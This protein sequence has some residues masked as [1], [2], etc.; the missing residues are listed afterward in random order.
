MPTA[1]QHFVTLSTANEDALRILKGETA[2]KLTDGFGGWD[3]TARPKQVGLTT[4]AGV[5][6]FKISIPVV[7]E[8][9]GDDTGQ[10]TRIHKLERM[11]MPVGSGEP[12]V[13]TLTGSGLPTRGVTQ[14]VIESLDWGDNVIWDFADDG[15]MVRMRQDCVINMIQ[16]VADDRVAFSR[17]PNVQPG[18]GAWPKHH[19]WH[20]GDTL[21]RLAAYFYHN[22]KRWNWIAD[23]N[24]IRDP[25]SIK[26]GRVI[27][28][29]KPR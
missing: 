6:P 28:I 3:I 7:F 13:V 25:K 15:S 11:A 9:W 1:K 20:A 27:K 26:V 16:Y 18:A 23:A 8:G 22:S 19:V 5:N 21:Q 2:P 12:A 24:N 4:W 29:P 17:L 14:W 10:E